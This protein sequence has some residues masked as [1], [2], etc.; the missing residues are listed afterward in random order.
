MFAKLSTLFLQSRYLAN[1][2][3]RFLRIRR[4][5]PPTPPPPPV[6]WIRIT[7]LWCGSGFWFFYFM[8]LR[9]WI[10]IRIFYPDVD[11]DPDPSFKKRV[12]SLKK[13]QNRLIFRIFWLVS[14]KLMRIRIRFRIQLINLMRIR[15]WVWIQIFIWCGSGSGRGS[16]FTKWS[17]SKTLRPTDVFL[18]LRNGKG[19]VL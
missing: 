14:F 15:M 4:K 6:L 5:Q 13:C 3:K 11:P 2:H 10:Q 9:M 17:V 7:S 12:K 8:R 16:R 1:I 19:N 18:I